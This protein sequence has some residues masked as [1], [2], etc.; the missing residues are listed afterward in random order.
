M[1][2][3]LNARVR[4]VE[5]YALASERGCARKR[6][7]TWEV[8]VGRL[9]RSLHRRPLQDV[10]LIVG[11]LAHFLPVR[12]AVVLRCQPLLLL[13]RLT[14]AR[15]GSRRDRRENAIAEALDLVA[16]E[17]RTQGLPCYEVDTTARTV[18]SVARSV[19]AIAR[20][21]IPSRPPHVDWL[22]DPSVTA[23]L[24]DADL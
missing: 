9:V 22:A 1:A 2:R 24:L 13:R 16:V 8:D 7:G 14:R 20:G 4:A 23:H 21:R 10:D 18:A 15:R 12:G 3:A 5:V 19:Q 6:G 11:H 17:V